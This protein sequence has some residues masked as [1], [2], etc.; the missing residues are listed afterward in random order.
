MGLL[1][2]RVAGA[3]GKALPGTMLRDV[4]F[5]CVLPIAGEIC[6]HEAVNDGIGC[7]NDEMLVDGI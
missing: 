3:V 2:M 4:A 1:L 6:V 5:A 7:T